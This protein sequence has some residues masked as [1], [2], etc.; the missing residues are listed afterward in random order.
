[1]NNKIITLSKKKYD[2]NDL[3][4]NASVLQLQFTKEYNHKKYQSIINEKKLHS[5]LSC[6]II[7]FC[8]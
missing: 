8:T 3:M 4:C 6:F 1:M 7:P 2:I 5:N